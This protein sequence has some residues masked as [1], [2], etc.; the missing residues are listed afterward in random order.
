MTQPENSTP[1]HEEPMVHP[2]DIRPLFPG[3]SGQDIV[4]ARLRSM[5]EVP[6]SIFG[7]CDTPD[8]LLSA[9]GL[10]PNPNARPEDL[11]WKSDVDTG[12]EGETIKSSL[13]IEA[14]PINPSDPLTRLTEHN[15]AIE[16]QP[17]PV[18]F[19]EY[20]ADLPGTMRAVGVTA[21]KAARDSLT[22]IA[23]PLRRKK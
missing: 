15:S 20:L 16:H 17:V 3:V 9:E 23:S 18:S 10:P 2:D 7:G 19:A 4:A 6:A 11:A 8:D 22:I 1:S 21:L 13:D 12:A 14:P 5:E